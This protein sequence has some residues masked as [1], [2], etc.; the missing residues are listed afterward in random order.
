VAS[1]TAVVRPTDLPWYETRGGR[2]AIY[3]SLAFITF[4]VACFFNPGWFVD[5]RKSW[6]SVPMLGVYVA[7]AA[8][9][10]VFVVGRDINGAHRWIHLGPIQIQ[11]SEIGKWGAVVYLAWLLGTRP[12][13]LNKFWTGFV[14]ACVPIGMIVLLVV[15]EDLGTAA[16]IGVVAAAM[17]VVGGAKL[18][19]LA[20]CV[21]PALAAGVYFLA[22]TPYRLTRVTAFLNPWEDPQGTGYHMIQSLL[23]FA[24]GGLTGVGLGNGV[25]K[26]GY[27]PEGETDFIY[28]VISEELGFAGAVIILVLF[29][30]LVLA[31]W[32]A[33]GDLSIRPTWR[34]LAFGIG[35]MIGVQALINVAVA[36]VSMPTKGMS[37][38]LVSAGG[39]VTVMAS[40][41]L[42]L[43][44]AVLAR[45]AQSGVAPVTTSGL[46]SPAT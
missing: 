14:P 23:S 3:A 31:A 43:L 17:L 35:T 22:G 6:W 36:T 25:Q 26:L 32:R 29:T 38:P 8:C 42:G 21:P 5:G 44:A 46:L 16:L 12:L 2:Q 20:V 15:I 1:A 18:W 40:A 11:V 9:A 33:V 19:H 39:S 10:L 41:M 28:A 30:G 34:L 24:T 7:I 45:R 13:D 4:A 37:L 27:L